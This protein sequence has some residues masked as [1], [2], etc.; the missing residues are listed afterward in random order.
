MAIIPQM[1]IFSWKMVET[2]SD[3]QRLELVLSS[4]PDEQLMRALEAER[5]GRRDDYPIRST[6]NTVIAGIVF[7]H[8]SVE[9][10]IR[11]LCR[12]AELRQTCGFD[13][14][15]GEK[16]VPKASVY[17]NFFKKLFRHQELI[18][19]MFDE[20]VDELQRLLPDIGKRL[21][22]DSKKLESYSVGKKDPLTS[23]DPDADWGSKTYKGVRKDG[24][25]WER[26]KKWFGYK[27]HLVV[28]SNYELPVAYKVTK[29]SVN[30]SP[31]LLPMVEGL[32]ERHPELLKKTEYLSGDKGYDS[33]KNNEILFD[34]YGIKPV[35]DTRAMWSDEPEFYRPLF[36][37]FDNIFYNEKGDVLCH[38]FSDEDLA[39]VKKYA[40]MAFDGYEKSRGCLKYLC[41]SK[42]YGIECKNIAECRYGRVVRVPLCKDR[43][44]FTP[45]ARSSYKWKNE[46]KHRTAVERV[47]SR[48]D[49]SFG[50]EKHFIRGFKKMRCRVGLA[51]VV[52]LAV[53]VGRIKANQ[54]ENM[55]SLV[56][57]TA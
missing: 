41:P 48:I 34:N 15:I 21:A 7:G 4:M 55:R 24:T 57:K 47:N 1:Q 38:R 42:A 32:K 22:V 23:S 45:V 54:A 17:T 51:L 52:M 20:L 14:T 3:L 27:L 2:S 37:D 44:I 31:Q 25:F 13:V 53:A 16:A 10:L 12:N 29:A 43:R 40:D 5:K 18:D 36:G 46:Y 30:D 26:V 11:E 6:W 28:D 35:I 19:A 39:E 49:M 50:F 8:E 33:A 9:S 56:K